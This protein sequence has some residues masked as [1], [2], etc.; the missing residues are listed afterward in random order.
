VQLFTPCLVHGAPEPGERTLVYGLVDGHV[1]AGNFARPPRA[2]QHAAQP[3]YGAQ[4]LID[5]PDKRKP[6]APLEDGPHCRRVLQAK[7]IGLGR[8]LDPVAI[9]GEAGD[10]AHTLRHPQKSDVAELGLGIAAADIGMRSGEPDLLD[11]LIGDGRCI[12]RPGPQ[13]GAERSAHLV[14]RQRMQSDVDRG[15][16]PRVVELE[17]AP[18]KAAGEEGVADIADRIPDADATDAHRVVSGRAK[19]LE[20]RI[21]SVFR[22]LAIDVPGILDGEARSLLGDAEQGNKAGQAAGLEGAAR[23]AEEEDLVARFVGIGQKAV[24]FQ[25][26][27]AQLVADGAFY[28]L[29]THAF[30]RIDPPDVARNLP[31]AVCVLGQ[32]VSVKLDDVGEDCSLFV[33]IPG[34]VQATN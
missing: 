19:P 29:R 21:T 30:G 14:D 33:T 9:D 26:A 28:E 17:P 11:M 32:N 2:D 12:A 31:D 15:V 16:Q 25:D 22:Q 18:D 1:G 6:A 24:A 27:I 7:R 4:V 3:R 20:R 10:G 5:Q 23:E 34:S 8:A 13:R